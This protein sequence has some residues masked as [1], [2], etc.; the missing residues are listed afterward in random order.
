MVLVDAETDK[1]LLVLD[2]AH[3][4]SRFAEGFPMPDV[5]NAILK[6][7]TEWEEEMRSVSGKKQLWEGTVSHEG[8]RDAVVE[9]R[10]LLYW[11]GESKLTW[12]ENEVYLSEGRTVL[13]KWKWE[14]LRL[15]EETLK[16]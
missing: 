1:L 6:R 14:S 13:L 5:Q 3:R 8:L 12:G 2:L 11:S 15:T 9:P 10:K 4:P 16:N 7:Q